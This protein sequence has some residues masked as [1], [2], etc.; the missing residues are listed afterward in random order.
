MIRIL[1][2]GEGT[3]ELGRYG[4]PNWAN[5]ADPDGALAA[6]LNRIRK[7]GWEVAEVLRWKDIK[8]YRAGNHA[9][10]EER[11]VRGAAERARFLKCDVLAFLRDQDDDEERARTIEAAI[12]V[13]SQTALKIA[14]GMATSCLEAWILVL[15]GQADAESLRKTRAQEGAKSLGLHTTEAMTTCIERADLSAVP[16]AAVTLKLWI[17]RAT[18]ALGH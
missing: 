18:G 17:Q 2:I 5:A 14:G 6:L 7:G 12:A 3:N 9:S 10:A 4:R 15:N 8:K 1:L 16:G 13:E 11:N